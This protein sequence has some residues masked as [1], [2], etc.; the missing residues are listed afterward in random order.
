MFKKIFRFL[1]PV[2]RNYYLMTALAFIVWIIFFDSNNV[3]SEYR[4]HNELKGLVQQKQYL[5]SEIAKNKAM[6]HNLTNPKD[7]RA[8]EKFAREKYL[9]KRENEEIFLIVNEK[10]EKD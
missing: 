6:V 8:V 2:V 1:K 5:E 10:P 7:L 4:N 9:M 3:I